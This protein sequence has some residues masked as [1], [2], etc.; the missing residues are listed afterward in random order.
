LALVLAGDLAL[1]QERQRLAQANLASAGLIEQI[2][3][4]DRGSP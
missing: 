2:I 1:A 3:E 4:P